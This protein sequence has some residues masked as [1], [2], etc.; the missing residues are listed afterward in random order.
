MNISLIICTFNRSESLRVTLQT[1]CCIDIPLGLSWE[2][3]I[4][5][6]NS[7]DATRTVCD[8]FLNKLP[9]R[10]VCE[11]RQGKSYALN[12]GVR[13]AHG[14]LLLFTDDDV[15]IHSGWISGLWNAYQRHPIRCF[16]GGRVLPIW[17]GQPPK[18]VREQYAELPLF[19]HLDWGAE[20]RLVDIFKGKLFIGPNCAF[21]AAVFREGLAYPMNVGLLESDIKRGYRVGGEDTEFV[22]IVSKAGWSGVYVPDAVVMHRHPVSR[23]SEQALRQWYIGSG[24][25]LVRLSETRL[26]TGL[27]LGAP[28]YLWKKLVM[29]ACAFVIAR[30]LRSSKVWVPA[31]CELALTWGKIVE[32]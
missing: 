6:N 1:A 18:W 14:D 24:M 15:K 17:E 20:E 8:S 21:P 2:V 12:A 19:P 10:Y 3:I 11:K 26:C 4:V 13:V 5:D 29:S 25:M 27:L 9:L 32:Y 31:E 22:R 30:C 28:R 7:S 16:F 23:Y